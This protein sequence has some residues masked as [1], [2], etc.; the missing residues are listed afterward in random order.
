LKRRKLKLTHN[1]VQRGDPLR[2]RR[3]VSVSAFVSVDNDVFLNPADTISTYNGNTWSF[4]E[5]QVLGG[6][7]VELGE[8]K[9]V[10]PGII[11]PKRPVDKVRMAMIEAMF[12]EEGIAVV[13]HDESIEER[14]ER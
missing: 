12:E 14:K 7:Y 13:W 5:S 3:P 9:D 1:I 10:C 8:G 11:F 6:E 2:I 4:I